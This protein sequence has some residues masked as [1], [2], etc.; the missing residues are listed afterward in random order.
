M[1]RE[2]HFSQDSVFF[3][4]IDE[5]DAS[6]AIVFLTS[7][8]PE[9]VDEA[10]LDRFLRYDLDAGEPDLLVEVLRRRGADYRLS[11]AQLD[12]MESEV[13]ETSR[14]RRLSFRDIDR[15]ALRA[16]VAMVVA[17]EAG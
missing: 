8:R 3:H 11:S 14:S 6:R 16:Y 1:T 2:W 9:L 12:E 13:R 17:S 7:N 10:I 4:V 5:L 15:M